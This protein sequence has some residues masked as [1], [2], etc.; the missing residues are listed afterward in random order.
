MFARVSPALVAFGGSVLLLGGLIGTLY[1]TS[2][3]GR[4][5]QGREPLIVYCAE[6][7][8]MPME[9]IAK[10]YEKEYRQKVEL[11]PGPSQTLLANLE[12][13]QKGDLFLPADD[14]YIDS[15]GKKG[16]IR[17]GDV[18]DLA[19]M[20]AVLIVNPDYPKKITNWDDFVAPGH[21]I[22][23]A[24]VE[25]SAIGK[26]LKQELQAIGKWDSLAQRNPNYLGNVNEVLN[27]VHKVKSNDVG[28]VWDVLAQPHPGALVV[29]LK[30]L[31]KVKAHVQIAVTKC[32]TQHDNALHFIC[33]MR[34]KDK[35]AIEFKKQGFADFEERGDMTPR[36]ELVVHAGAMLQPALEDAIRAFEKREN[37]RIT[38]VYN[39]CGILVSQMKVG[40]TPDVFFACDTS[41]MTQVEDR[42]KP[43]VN[44]S[45]N[46]LVIAVKKGNPKQVFKLPDL[47]KVMNPQLRVGVGHEHQC[48]LGALTQET[49]IRTG[50]LAQVMKNVVVQSPTGDMLVNQLR[51]GSLDVVVAYRSNVTAFK[52]EL[53]WTPITEVRCATPSQPIAVSKNSTHPEIS[54]RL[55]DYLRTAESRERFEKLGFGWEVKEV[56]APQKK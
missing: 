19:R 13:M 36:A 43:S 9:A 5:E 4:P 8:R 32:S 34:A 49:F 11:R 39:G 48:A 20:H 18:L 23:L 1:W 16:L 50:V 26:L 31:E 6:A 24:N 46:Q 51:A 41:F 35:G 53:D 29:N 17:S 14:S 40:D 3:T 44:V 12:L 22:G 28:I 2:D 52:D 45:T 42:F 55:M 56:E 37:V 15:A 21:K 25:V 47:G 54:K 27:S 30:E 33:Y 7:L 38:R 10:E